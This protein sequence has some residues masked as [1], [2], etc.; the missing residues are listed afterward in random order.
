[1]VIAASMR[2]TS[3]CAPTPEV[4]RPTSA[5]SAPRPRARRPA[6]G[7]GGAGLVQGTE[8][9]AA[10]V[11]IAGRR[12][13]HVAERR[14]VGVRA[15]LTIARDGH[16]TDARVERLEGPEWEPESLKV[17]GAEVL[18]D[19]ID[20]GDELA[21]QLPPLRLAPVQ[22]DAL[23][24]AVIDRVIDGVALVHRTGK[25]AVSLALRVLYP[26]DLGAHVGE[27]RSRREAPPGTA[28]GRGPGFP[29]AGARIEGPAP[30]PSPALPAAEDRVALLGERCGALPEV[31]RQMEGTVALEPGL[32]LELLH[33]A[34]PD[35]RPLP[36]PRAVG[37]PSCHRRIPLPPL[38]DL[39]EARADRR[40]LALPLPRR[41]RSGRSGRHPTRSRRPHGGTGG[42]RSWRPTVPA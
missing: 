33:R 5:P 18:D 26:D 42:A 12:K 25:A 38:S 3:T 7:D 17:S 22:P 34:A 21:E 23:L 40:H 16:E 39:L 10:D 2:E 1:M 13:G 6:V 41:S 31:L 24:A 9:V 35:S 20:L 37:W 15:I 30:R 19:D 28:T 8:R 29:R 14:L 27:V 36:A 32:E 11:Q 4:A